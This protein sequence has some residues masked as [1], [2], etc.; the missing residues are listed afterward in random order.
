MRLGIIAL[1]VTAALVTACGD[2]QDGSSDGEPQLRAVA[3]LNIIADLVRQVAG[4]RVQVDALLPSGADPHTY[5]PTPSQVRL[6]VEAD[7]VFVNGLG[8]EEAIL[9]VIDPNLPDDVPLVELAEEAGVELRQ[10]DGRTDPHVWLSVDNA[11]EYV[12]LIRDGLTAVDA[13]GAAA[14]EENYASYLQRLDELDD[15]ARNAVSSVPD[16][17]RRLVSTHDAFGYL[18]SYLGFEVA[19]VVST[20]PGQ[21]PSASDIA[22]LRDVIR[23]TGVSAV[24]EEPQLGAQSDALRQAADDLGV[25]VCTLYSGALDDDVRTYIDMIR[26][27]ADE[28]ARCLS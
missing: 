16:D 7:A 9:N 2:S 4:D 22:D 6:I 8:L 11:R 21:E 3:S 14:Y 15:Y 28:I 13:P 17:R 19:G 5:E 10:H 1:A 25:G 18:A 23:Q 20:S 27:N 26:F 24:F 12:R